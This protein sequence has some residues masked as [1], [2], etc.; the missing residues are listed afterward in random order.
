MSNMPAMLRNYV[1]MY[2]RRACSYWRFLDA[3][4]SSGDRAV[5]SAPDPDSAR[6]TCSCGACERGSMPSAPGVDTCHFIAVVAASVGRIIL[7]PHASRTALGAREFGAAHF[8]LL[9]AVHTLF[10][11]SLTCEVCFLGAR[12]GAAWPLLLVLWLGAQALRYAAIRAL[13]DRWNVRA[14][15][16]SRVRRSCNAVRI[17]SFGIPTTSPS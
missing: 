7:P 17:A 3:G 14:F 11:V 6:I 10:L 2:R 9:V 15:S 16:W 8:P 12:P 1:N 5:V 4:P 13:G